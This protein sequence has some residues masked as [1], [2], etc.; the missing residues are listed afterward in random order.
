MYWPGT[1]AQWFEAHDSFGV[2]EVG[3]KWGLAEGRVGG[4]AMF[5][6]FILLANA[7]TTAADVTVTYLRENGSTL[8][9]QY[10]VEPTSRFNIWANAVG[11]E[12]ANERFGAL[13]EVTNGVPI[14]VER[15]MYNSSAGVLF[16]GGSNAT[17]TRIP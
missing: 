10:T 4:P 8:V 11:P 7:G 5:E 1:F 9:R 14:A 6:T 16:A 13:I 15:A 3:T 17:A 2:T 12:L